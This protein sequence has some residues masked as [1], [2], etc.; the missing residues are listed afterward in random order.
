VNA[1]AAQPQSPVPSRQKSPVRRGRSSAGFC[2]LPPT[3][4][5]SAQERNHIRSIVILAG[6]L[7]WL[8]GR[9]HSLVDEIVN[10]LLARYQFC[11]LPNGGNLPLKSNAP[12]HALGVARS[13]SV[14]FT[15]ARCLRRSSPSLSRRS[16][17]AR[18]TRPYR[19][20]HTTPSSFQKNGALTV[21]RGVWAVSK[22]LNA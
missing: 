2:V 16:L 13:A 17:S 22:R 20:R 1:A 19:A 5:P 10:P 12:D 7:K 3:S 6:D 9:R 18:W 4:A 14:Y 11:I 8:I 21:V 15:I